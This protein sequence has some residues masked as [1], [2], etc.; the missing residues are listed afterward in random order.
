MLLAMEVLSQ[1][2]TKIAFRFAS[3]CCW[4]CLL[5]TRT[6]AL[7]VLV[8]V[9]LSYYLF[10]YLGFHLRVLFGPMLGVHCDGLVIGGG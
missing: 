9:W 7:L 2:H 1:R 3:G 6:L 4:C 5:E 8:I 10:D